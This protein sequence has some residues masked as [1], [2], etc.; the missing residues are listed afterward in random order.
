MTYCL[1]IY[2]LGA[3]VTYFMVMGFLRCAGLMLILIQESFD[4]DPI[5]VSI[6]VTLLASGIFGFGK[7]RKKK[8]PE[9]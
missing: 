4:P 2:M 6:L 3:F 1:Y 7:D 8:V 5:V 9:L